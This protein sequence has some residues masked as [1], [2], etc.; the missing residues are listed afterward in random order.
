MSLDYYT[1]L[2]ATQATCFSNK[3][4][5]VWL[6]SDRKPPVCQKFGVGKCP[7]PGQLQICNHPTPGTYK[8]GKCPAVAQVGGE[9]GGAGR[10]W[11]WLMHY[12]QEQILDPLMTVLVIFV[13]ILPM[14]IPFQ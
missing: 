8:V 14:H 6:Y 9:G 2:P 7:A 13:W 11:Y 3:I 1:I 4:L 10:S 12:W 5:T